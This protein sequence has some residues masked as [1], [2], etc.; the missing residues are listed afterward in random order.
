MGADFEWEPC[1]PTE[2]TSDQAA[3]PTFSAAGHAPP[4]GQAKPSQTTPNATATDLA[5]I[6]EDIVAAE[7]FIANRKL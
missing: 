3:S 4:P 2:A 7:R 1:Q 5:C 6:A